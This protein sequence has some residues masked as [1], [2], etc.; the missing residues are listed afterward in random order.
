M[1][2][3]L[4]SEEV[5]LCEVANEVEA[6]LVVNLLKDEGI[7]ARSDATTAGGVFGGLPFESGHGVYVT[8]NNARRAVAVLSN[9]PHFKDLKHVHE[10]I[11]D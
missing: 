9:Y 4:Q 7:P 1:S 3:E 6:T 8:G 5:R 10:P 11:S 2:D